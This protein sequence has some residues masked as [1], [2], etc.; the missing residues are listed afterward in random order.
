M[1]MKNIA[2]SLIALLA[3]VF[4]VNAAEVS[5]QAKAVLVEIEKANDSVNTLSSPLTEIKTMPNGRQ[6]VSTGDFYFSSPDLLA[7]RYTS[8]AGDYLVVNAEE[9]AQKKKNGKS[10]KFSLEK[11]ETM[12]TLSSTLL[13]CVSGKLLK[14]AE[15]NKADVNVSESGD[16]LQV[17]LTAE[18]KTERGFKKIE[19]SY[20]KTTMRLKSM[21]M[22]DKN[23]VVTKYTMDKPQYG[24]AIDSSVFQI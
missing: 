14:L 5:E 11:N 13:W 7:I 8:P 20:D 1:T 6:F 15:A 17:V 18:V 4:S 19:L 2:V 24:V 9:I 12:K 3:A 21:A 22:T 16:V 23:N 10:F